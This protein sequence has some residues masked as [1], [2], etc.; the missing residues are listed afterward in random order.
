MQAARWGESINDFHPRA[1]RFVFAD[2]LWY[3]QTREEGV[4]G[5]FKTQQE[6]D[7]G[8]SSYLMDLLDQNRIF[9]A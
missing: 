9:A 8:L 5:P 4:F 1:S 3:F 2:G 6:A 7:E